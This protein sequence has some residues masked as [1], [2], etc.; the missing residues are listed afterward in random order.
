MVSYFLP[1]A[2]V[3]LASSGFYDGPGCFVV[4]IMKCMTDSCMKSCYYVHFLYT[5]AKLVYLFSME[6]LKFI[7]DTSV[8]YAIYIA[9][10]IYAQKWLLCKDCRD[11]HLLFQRVLPI[12]LNTT[13][14]IC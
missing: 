3:I 13:E 9:V 7:L 2:F 8:H 5:E 10:A 12:R 14:R 4:Y 6:L 1:L 11:V